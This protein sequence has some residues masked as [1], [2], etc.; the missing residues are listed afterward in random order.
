MAIS[1]APGGQRSFG[2][3]HVGDEQIKEAVSQNMNLTSPGICK[4]L[5]VNTANYQPT[6]T[7]RHF[8]VRLMRMVGLAGKNPI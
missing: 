2:T 5:L 6:A 8:A 3:G 4:N 7:Y 1:S